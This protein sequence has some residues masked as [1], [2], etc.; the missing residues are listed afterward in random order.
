MLK[1]DIKQGSLTEEQIK[2]FEKAF[3]RCARRIILS[4][5]L[6]GCG[7]PGGSLSSL[8]LLLVVYSLAK[9]NPQNPRALE[10]D[11]ILISHGHISPGVYS[12]LCEYGFFPEEPFLMEFRR[13]GSAFA[14]HVEQSVP[15]VEWNTGNL[16]QGLSAACGMAQALKLKNLSNLVFC[17]MGDGEQQKGQVIEAR[18]WAVKFKLDNLITLIDYNQLQIGGKISEVMPQDLKAEI[19]ATK[20]NVLE[21]DGHD[22]QQIFQALKVAIEKKVSNPEHPTAIIAHTV[23]GKG[24]SFMENDPKWHGMALPEDLAKKALEELGFDPGELDVLK[25]KRKTWNVSFPHQNYD[26]LPIE[27]K[28][29]AP[30]IYPPEVNTDCRSAYGKALLNLAKENNPPTGT[31][32]ILGLTCDLEGSVKMT[33]FKKWSPQAFFESGIQEHHTAS[34]AGALSKEGF[35][36]FF[37]TFGVFAIDEVYNQL[38]INSINRTALKVVATHLGADVGEDGPTHQCIDYIG[39]LLNL[40]DFEI[41]ITADPNQTDHI[42]RY[43]ADKPRN[44]FVGMGRSKLPVVTK[45]DGSLYFDE[46]YTFIPGKADWIRQGDKGVIITYGTMIPYALKAWEILNSEGIKVSLLNVASIRPFPEKDLLKASELKN[47]IIVEDHLVETGLGTRI[48]SFFGL[49]QIKV[50]LKLLGH[51]TIC[52]SGKPSELF[53][54][55]GLDP[56]SIAH[57]MK[58]MLK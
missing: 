30:T 5:T 29:P 39:L 19:E 11:R 43:I 50:N 40:Y 38:R 32:K 34:V 51:K 12:V 53:K 22:F 16:G 4:T 8:S 33:D 42:I 20:W 17:F 35:S 25:E 2:W 21:I 1:I 9:V 18:R 37:S 36:V 13:A 56:E 45:E 52:S 46:N 28:I 48:A 23:M 6:A 27:L 47:L 14:G 54:Q 44:I 41:Y 24:I 15:G 26:P 7:H 3:R 10:R 57:T 31:P 58:Q 55:A 49:K